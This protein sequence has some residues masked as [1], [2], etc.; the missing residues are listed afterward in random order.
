MIAMNVRSDRRSMGWGFQ[1]LPTAK[2]TK[3]KFLILV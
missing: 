1:H 2:G 3:I